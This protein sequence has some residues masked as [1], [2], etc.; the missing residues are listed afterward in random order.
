MF[1]FQKRGIPAVGNFPFLQH[2]AHDHFDVLVID[3]HTLQ[4]IHVLHFVDH[5]IG[6]RLNAHDSKNIVRRRVAIHDIVA[7]LDVITFDHW[8]VLAFWHHVFH[9]LQTFIRRF[10][11][12]AAFVLIVPSKA[13]IAIDFGDD[14]VV[15]GATRL[16]EFRN[17]RQTTRDV[18]G[19]CTFTRDTRN[20]IACRNALPVFDRQDGIYRHRICNRISVCPTHGFA[21]FIHQNNLGF[22]F[23]AFGCSTPI[24][25]DFLCHT[26]CIVRFITHGN[27]ADQINIFNR[28]ALFGNDGQCIGVPFKELIAPRNF[29]FLCN[30][31]F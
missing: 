28:A 24:G 31:E 21:I 27:P 1:A 15:F 8:N 12:D 17:P 11:T 3:L 22:Q 29:G 10:D 2:L 9:W 6:K 30:K 16:K 26:G 5:V 7:F 13:H 20:N 14:R 4:A 18:L 19:F 25:Y 23:I